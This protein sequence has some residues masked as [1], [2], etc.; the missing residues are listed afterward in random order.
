MK[1][2][3]RINESSDDLINHCFHFLRYSGGHKLWQEKFDQGLDFLKSLNLTEEQYKE[4]GKLWELYEDFVR[5]REEYR[6]IDNE[7]Y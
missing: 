2:I 7:E 5:E 1:H 3:K 4:L 6:D